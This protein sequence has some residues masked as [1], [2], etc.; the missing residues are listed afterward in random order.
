MNRW[1]SAITQSRANTLRCS[2]IER[3]VMPVEC[4]RLDLIWTVCFPMLASCCNVSPVYVRTVLPSIRTQWFVLPKFL[5]SSLSFNF[6]S[7][8][9]FSFNQCLILSL[10]G[11]IFYYSQYFILIC[12]LQF[13]RV[14]H[15]QRREIGVSVSSVVGFL[16]S[17]LDNCWRVS[18][19]HGWHFGFTGTRE[20]VLKG[21]VQV[22]PMGGA[23]KWVASSAIQR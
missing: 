6:R 23:A 15:S 11:H 20:S 21:V 19:S 4:N 3:H 12:I 8:D 14:L 7:F 17:S 5:I 10:P 9:A 22:S 18:D 2:P 1:S 13:S 16:L